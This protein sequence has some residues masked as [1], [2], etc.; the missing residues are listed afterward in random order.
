MS[1]KLLASQEHNMLFLIS[2]L[3]SGTVYITILWFV[4]LSS[5]ITAY[6]CFEGIF[7]LHLK[8]QNKW[9]EDISS[10]YGHTARAL[11]IRMG[12]GG[13]SSCEQKI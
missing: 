7:C 3:H 4:T 11:V 12:A 1:G 9:I 6:E 13:Q 10:V 5:L 2:D 8:V